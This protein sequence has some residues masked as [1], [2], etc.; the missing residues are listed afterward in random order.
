M[1]LVSRILQYF[2]KQIDA[3]FT[4]NS[5]IWDA[6]VVLCIKNGKDTYQ[7]WLK[8]LTIIYN[9]TLTHFGKVSYNIRNHTTLLHVALVYYC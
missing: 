3:K 2:F 7:A 4:V 6:L 9:I 8:L 1:S 5:S